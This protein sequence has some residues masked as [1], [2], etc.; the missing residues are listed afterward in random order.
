MPADRKIIHIDCDCFYASI[1]MRDTPAWRGIPLAV[2]GRPDSR[3]VI[4]TCNY[5]ARQFGIHSA[6]SSRRALTLCP[7]LLIVP[8]DMARYREASNRIM[9]IYGDYTSRIEPL[10]LD[11]AYL[12][13]TGQPHC[14]G[15]AT[16]MAKAIRDRIRQEIGITAS[17]GIAPNKFLAKVASDWNKP[18]GQKVILPHEIDAFVAALPVGKVPGIGKVTAERMKRMGIL[19]C[20]DLRQWSLAE[21]LHQFGRFGER[22]HRLARGEDERE[23]SVDRVR[24]SVSVEETYATDLPDLAACL[25][26][27]PELLERLR[28]RLGRAGNPPFRGIVCKLKFAD[29]TQTTVE[30]I[31]SAFDDA[32]FAQLMQMGFARGEQPV[33]LLG[34]GVKLAEEEATIAAQLP[35]FD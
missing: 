15:S 28:E 2:G 23:V 30:Q 20:G 8:P 5:E 27:L 21:L 29:F 22:L 10:S 24:K 4:A 13:V 16:L 33:R 14:R 19:T 35:L 34:V 18:D 9:Q 7:R 25:Q 11:E 12:D 1:E 17:A 26:A 31:G 32:H 3:G 6:M